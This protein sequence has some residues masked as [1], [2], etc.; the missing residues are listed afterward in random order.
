VEERYGSPI[1]QGL[2][3]MQGQLPGNQYVEYPRQG[4]CAAADAPLKA[5]CGRRTA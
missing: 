4:L 1:V 2:A 3:L 5:V